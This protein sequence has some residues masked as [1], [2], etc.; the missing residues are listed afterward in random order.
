[1]NKITNIIKE[2]LKTDLPEFR[3][4]DSVSVDVKVIEGNRSR[5]QSFE[6]VVISISAGHDIF[7]IITLWTI[8]FRINSNIIS[9]ISSLN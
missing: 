7:N 6:G 5:L 3:S 9:N 4:G 2:D 8:R 1:M